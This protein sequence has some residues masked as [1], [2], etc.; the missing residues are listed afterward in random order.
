MTLSGLLI[1]YCARGF[2][3]III[4]KNGFSVVV[5]IRQLRGGGGGGV[6]EI[7]REENEEGGKGK[8]N[9]C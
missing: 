9:V 6:E 5:S 1:I 2:T 7:A 3:K 4:F 8:I